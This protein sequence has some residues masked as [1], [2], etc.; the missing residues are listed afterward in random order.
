MTNEQF[1]LSGKDDSKFNVY[2]WGY[3]DKKPVV[4][5][6]HGIGEHA[7]NMMSLQTF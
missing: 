4:Q 6:A 3:G 5:I 2:K 7:K 1:E